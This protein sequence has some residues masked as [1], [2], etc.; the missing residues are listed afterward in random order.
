MP[1]NIACSNEEKVVGN[2][3]Q[4]MSAGGHPAQVDGA[5]RIEV[6]SGDGT[7]AQDPASPLVFDAISGDALADTVYLVSADADLG[8][9]VELIQTTVTLTVTGAKASAFGFSGGNVVPKSAAPQ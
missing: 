6:Q 7:F 9:G 4:P 5:L 2:K 8:A 3:L 1:N